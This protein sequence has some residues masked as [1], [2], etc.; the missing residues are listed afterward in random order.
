MPLNDQISQMNKLRKEMVRIIL[1][2][3][4]FIATEFLGTM[5]FYSNSKNPPC[6][7]LLYLTLFLACLKTMYLLV[8]LKKK[9]NPKFNFV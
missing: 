2:V 6:K 8:R 9:E 1:N 7:I 4:N 3:M 5:Y